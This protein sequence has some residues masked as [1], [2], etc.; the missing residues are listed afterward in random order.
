MEIINNFLNFKLV[1]VSGYEFRVFTLL[2]LILIYIATRILIWSVNKALNTKNSFT[3]LDKAKSY[4]IFQIIKYI[5]W[6]IAIA[7]FLE[8]LGIK[9]TLL[10]AGSA[11]LLVGVGLGL[12]QTFNDFISGIILLAEGGIKVGDVLELDG[13]VVMIQSIDLRTSKGLTRD[14]I[15]ILIPNS[16][17][18]SNRVIN[19]SHQSRRTRF[20]INVGVAYGSDVDLVC[21]VLREAAEEHPDVTEKQLLEVRLIDF[22]NSSINFQLIFFSSNVFYIE[23]VKSDIRKS[24]SKKF[25]AA[26]IVIPF[27]QVDVHM[28]DTETK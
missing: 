18:T 20:K 10:L 1:Q 16:N 2:T 11:A 21:R 8:T 14:E 6:L 13:Q 12:Q 28:K 27:P 23:R 4:A 5:V 3:N 7:L 17:L 19:W 9:I 25:Q 26:G 24:I 15:M 22:G